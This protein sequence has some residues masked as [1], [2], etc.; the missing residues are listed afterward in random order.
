MR[1]HFSSILRRHGKQSRKNCAHG[2]S[3][4]LLIDAWRCILSLPNQPL[5]SWGNRRSEL[6][7]GNDCFLYILY[8]IHILYTYIPYMMYLYGHFVYYTYTYT[9]I[10]I[11]TY[12]YIHINIYIYTYRPKWLM[13]A[14][15]H[16]KLQQISTFMASGW[17]SFFPK[18]P[19]PWRC[20]KPNH[21]AYW[22]PIF[23]ICFTICLITMT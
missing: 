13:Y 22:Y 20:G 7:S 2:R 12:I 10:Y 16:G 18:S 3:W 15:C 21:Q 11:Y 14:C 9:H 5:A 1:F 23:T 8:S 6:S 17:L 4:V 19:R